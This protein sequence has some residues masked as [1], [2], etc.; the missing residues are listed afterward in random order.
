M[1][2]HART[3]SST[4]EQ[5]RADAVRRLKHGSAP[6]S[7]G[8]TISAEALALLYRLAS[9]PDSAGDALKLLH[10]LQ[11][12]QV[13]LDLQH[14][15]I[16]ANELELSEDLRHYRTLFEHAPVGYF[17]VD[18][19]GQVIETNRIG[20]ESL[21]MDAREARGRR[22]DVFLDADSRP[23]LTACLKTLRQ[24]GSR[25]VC[26]VNAGR[27]GHA[28]RVLHIVADVAPGGDAV[29]LVMSE[30]G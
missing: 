23:T 24:G 10:E 26:H 8:W 20:A 1:D 27:H 7:R 29:L 11:A 22:L 30:A 13:E 18:F 3:G 21:G 5:L 2:E 15:H 19:D 17:M 4:E 28:P 9:N 12:H 14:E 25:T 6:R 16:K